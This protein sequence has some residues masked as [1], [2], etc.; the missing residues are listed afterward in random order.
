MKLHIIISLQ[1]FCLNSFV[2]YLYLT[3]LFNYNAEMFFKKYIK[4]NMN[5]E[6][7]EGTVVSA[8]GS[9]PEGRQLPCRSPLF[10]RVCMFSLCVHGFIGGVSHSNM[11]YNQ[12]EAINSSSSSSSMKF[13]KCSIARFSAV[14]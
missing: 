10:L 6:L 1:C 7:H 9:Q 5:A 12:L 8:V 4:C 13:S 14:F 3:L 11:H 2:K